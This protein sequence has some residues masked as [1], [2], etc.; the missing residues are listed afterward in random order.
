MSLHIVRHLLQSSLRTWAAMAKR[1][2]NSLDIRI[3]TAHTAAVNPS[4]QIHLQP[5]SA[6]YLMALVM[7]G[8]PNCDTVKKARMWLTENQIAYTFHDF[9]KDG[10]T[11]ATLHSFLQDIPLD[12]LLN[13]YSTSWRKLSDAARAAAGQP[14]QALALLVENP[15]MIKRPVLV[16]ENAKVVGF[17]DELYSAFLRDIHQL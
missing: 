16:S 9:K 3:G 15:T 10:I 12:T 6:R 7:Y 2:T 1:I 4:N 17:S 5:I 14:N 11:L 8:I 13:R